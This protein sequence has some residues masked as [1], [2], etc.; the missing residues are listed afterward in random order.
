MDTKILSGIEASHALYDSL[1]DRIHALKEKGITPGLAAILVGEDPASQIYVRNKTKRFDALGLKSDLYRL[2]DSVSE[3]ELLDLIA[4]INADDSFHGIL[5]QL[6]LPKHIDSDKVIHAIDPKK[7]VDGFHPENAGLLSI[8]RPRFVPCTPKGI[9]F[10]LK[11]FNVDLN[12][13]HVVVVGRSNIVGRPVSVLSSLKSLGNATVTLCHSGTSD[14]KYFTKQADVVVAAMGSPE[15]LDASFIKEGACLVDV[16]INRIERDGK[17]IIVG[18]VN[19]SS[20]TGKA[21]SLTPVPRGVGPMTIAML[22]ENTIVSAEL[23]LL[24]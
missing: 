23:L 6:P 2:E 13:K 7:D 10:I 24:N 5:V 1:H 16:G 12:G 4:K 22:V 11:H 8:G 19:Q 14:L 21:S 9:M 3:Q 20:V 17:S 18:D 15:F